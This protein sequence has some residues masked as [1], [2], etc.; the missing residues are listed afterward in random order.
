MLLPHNF[1]EVNQLLMLLSSMF[2]LFMQ[3]GN[4]SRTASFADDG[5]ILDGMITRSRGEFR[6][7]CSLKVV[8]SPGT[9]SKELTGIQSPRFSDKVYSPRVNQLRENHSPRGVGRGPFS[10]G[11]AKPSNLRKSG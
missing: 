5:E 2:V 1:F 7:V 9:P 3:E 10:P 11:E 4:L 8:S 6:R